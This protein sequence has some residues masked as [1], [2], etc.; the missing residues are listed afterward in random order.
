MWTFV[1]WTT[2]H[3]GSHPCRKMRHDNLFDD[4]IAHSSIV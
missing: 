2:P 3:N 1:F 4:I